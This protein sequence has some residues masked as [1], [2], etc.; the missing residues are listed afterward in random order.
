MV[1]VTQ[2][3]G[4]TFLLSEL[5]KCPLL[6][7]IR[8]PSNID[9]LGDNL[10]N[11]DLKL[12]NP[13]SYHFQQDYDTKYPMHYESYGCYNM[14]QINRKRFNSRQTSV[15]LKIYVIFWI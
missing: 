8:M 6:N 9:T 5:V 13:N 7:A 1:V 12:G 3:L 4:D 15:V 14:Q 11:C 2:C 10:C